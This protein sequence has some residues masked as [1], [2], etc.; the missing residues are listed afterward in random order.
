MP[1]S[2][3]AVADRHHVAALERGKPEVGR[4]EPAVGALGRVPELELAP[5]EHRVRPVDGGDVVGLPPA[6]RPEHR[7]DRDAAVDPAR[8]VAGEQRVRA[9]AGARTALV[10]SSAAPISDVP[11]TAARSSPDSATVSP[12][13]EVLGQLVRLEVRQQRPGP[14]RPAT[15]RPCTPTTTSSMSRSRP[16]SLA[17]SASASRSCRRNTS[18]PRSR[19]RGDELVVLVLRAL[20]PEHV[21]EQQLVVVRRREA[22]QAQVRSV[23][24]DLAQ[25]AHLRVHT[26]LAHRTVLPFDV[27]QL[28]HDGRAGPALHDLLDVLERADGGALA[29]RLD[30]PA[31]RRRPS[32]P[33][34]RR[35]TSCV[36]SSSG[37]TRSSRRCSGVPQ[38]S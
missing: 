33:S 8:R 29:G 38:P 30:E 35:R 5:R 18:T 12:P 24:H 9:A 3:G 15:S 31:W 22:L 20:D 32:G 37:V 1:M 2:T 26:E 19:M 13:I 36:R 7:V 27:R 23:D 10:S 16:S 21:V 11:A 17:A 34:T 28:G 25:L 4:L 14:R 6:C